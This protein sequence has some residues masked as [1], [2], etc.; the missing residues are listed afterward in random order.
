MPPSIL[1]EIVSPDFENRLAA[2]AA[3]S[4]DIW[5]RGLAACTTDDERLE[6][7]H[8]VIEHF[9]AVRRSWLQRSH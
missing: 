7:A 8:R 9:T 5:G 2:C 6:W 3:L 4:A 1:E